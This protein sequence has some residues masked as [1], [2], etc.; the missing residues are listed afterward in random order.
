MHS[1]EGEG[2]STAGHGPSETTPFAL[3]LSL[4]FNPLSSSNTPIQYVFIQFN[5]YNEPEDVRD[6]FRLVNLTMTASLQRY[7]LRVTMFF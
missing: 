3:R 7:L 5:G 2:V 4:N 1:P 6:L